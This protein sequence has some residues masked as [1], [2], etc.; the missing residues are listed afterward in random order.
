MTV[1]PELSTRLS[2]WVAGVGVGGEA[3]EGDLRQEVY[4]R[5]RLWQH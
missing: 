4:P 3:E 5:S 2:L 1:R